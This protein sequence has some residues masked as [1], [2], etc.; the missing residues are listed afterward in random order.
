MK[1]SELI[2]HLKAFPQHANVVVFTET[3]PLY[4][5]RIMSPMCGSTDVWLFEDSFPQYGPE[6]IVR[7]VCTCPGDVLPIR[8]TCPLHGDR[9][10]S[11]ASTAR[12]TYLIARS[13]K[14]Q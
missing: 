7:P 14:R 12:S 1:V 13:S 9:K 6:T 3:G 8:A 2:E 4:V 11:G 10:R 5:E